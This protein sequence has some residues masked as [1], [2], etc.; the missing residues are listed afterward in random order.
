MKNRFSIKSLILH[1]S[2]RL[3][4]AKGFPV[5]LGTRKA[6]RRQWRHRKSAGMANSPEPVKIETS[7][8]NVPMKKLYTGK[9]A[10]EVNHLRTLLGLEGIEAQAR[11][12]YSAPA[13]G[14]IPYEDSLPQLWV[15]E[16]DYERAA[17]ILNHE[18]ATNN[19]DFKIWSC[20]RCQEEID[21]VYG[22]CWNCG[23][24]AEG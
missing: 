4:I 21:G 24:I 13:F 10:I 16:R 8:C 20:P 3:L 7:G 5:T 12:T 23:Y 2:S 17:R 14:E 22:Q 6:G 19:D 15:R 11:N 1:D 9:N 18:M